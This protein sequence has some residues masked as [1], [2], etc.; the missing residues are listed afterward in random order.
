MEWRTATKGG[1]PLDI[2]GIVDELRA[3]RL[4][5]DAAIAALSGGAVTRNRRS[6]P[7]G[8][9]TM[10]AEARAR[11][12]AAQRARWAKQKKNSKGS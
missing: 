2:E 9:R 8:R 11:I 1:L 3:E 5:L 4:R 12:A 6:R 10:S 7:R